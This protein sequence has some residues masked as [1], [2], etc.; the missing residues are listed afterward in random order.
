M[1]VNKEFVT[2]VLAYPIFP[3]VGVA[4][5]SGFIKLYSHFI[6]TPISP[7]DKV[8]S[9]VM[10][11]FIAGLLSCLIIAYP[12]LRIYKRNS[13]YVIALVSFSV[14]AFFYA[15]L[16]SKVSIHSD[17]LTIL[18]ALIYLLTHPLCSFIMFGLLWRRFVR[19]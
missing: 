1:K 14:T 8:I 3:V 4:L 12:M 6:Y 9:S 10:Q 11:G 16:F 18:V 19:D 17:S 2:R 5:Y 15:P 7:W 13:S